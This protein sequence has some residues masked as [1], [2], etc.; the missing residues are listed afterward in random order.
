MAASGNTTSPY[1]RAVSV[2]NIKPSDMKRHLLII[3]CLLS[4]LTAKG[5]S[6]K[7]VYLGT[8][9]LQIPTLTING[10]ISFDIKPYLSPIIDLGY[11]FNYSKG[12]DFIG[13]ALTP[14][15]KCSN[16]GYDLNNQSGGYIKLGV[17]LNLRKDF[18]RRNYPFIGL[19][20]TNS[21]VHEKG[22]YL[23]P[24]QSIPIEI[25]VNQTKY[26]IGF[27]SSLGYGFSL[28]E[29]LKSNIE[30]QISYPSKKYQDLY[31]YRNYIPGMGF[32]DYDG[33][34]FPM[35]IWNLKY[36]L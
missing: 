16:D 22:I 32:K 7:A 5:Q 15:C 19:F 12:F 35:L 21:F 8:N 1:C 26:I 24:E 34:W 10:N 27:S 33:Y 17:F 13:Y 28:T 20:L 23:P 14:H 18:S 30:F 11:T 6:N 31:G 9:L 4:F 25:Q 3:L 36:R 29:R 2:H